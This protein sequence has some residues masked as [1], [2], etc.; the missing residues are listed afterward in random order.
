MTT[1]WTNEAAIRQW[2]AIPRAVIEA[3][4]PD[5]DFAKRHLVNPVLLRMLGDLRGRRVLDAGCGEGYFSR[6]LAGRE[7]EVVGVEPTDAM[8]S[9]ARDKERELRQ[10]IRYVQADL[11]SLPDLGGPFDAVVC[12]MVLSAIPD[13]RPAMRA[14]VQVLWPGG[15]FVFSVNHP[16][17]ERLWRTWREHGEYR[18]RSYLAEYEIVQTH[19]SDFHRPI[20]A[21]LNEL[22]A[23][24]CRLR[25]LAEPGLD[26]ATAE[27][28]ER[29]TPGIESYVRLPN[30]LIAAAESPL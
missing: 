14:C 5:G 22:A 30:F 7:A 18:L 15:L 17:F 13:W 2:H 19:A 4:E 9:Y 11:T 3:M 20:S 26:P 12:S 8:F 27:E 1:Q 10:G 24:G 25:E 29:A 28:A 23:L 6:M 16:A 21:Y